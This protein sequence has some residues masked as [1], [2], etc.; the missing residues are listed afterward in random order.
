MI[1]L[2][3]VQDADFDSVRIIRGDGA[4]VGMLKALEEPAGWKPVQIQLLSQFQGQGIGT[5]VIS[6]LIDQACAAG[7]PLSLSV[8]KVNPA[9]RLYERL[10]FTVVEEKTFAYEMRIG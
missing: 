4:D 10:G 3:D 8:L 1:E 6:T 5:Q 2:R 9:K 7:V